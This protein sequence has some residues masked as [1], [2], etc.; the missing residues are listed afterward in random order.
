MNS[1]LRF[2][3]PVFGPACQALPDFLRAR[4]YRNPMA[5]DV[6][7]FQVAFNTEL[8]FPEFVKQ[9]PEHLENLHKSMQQSY[10]NQWIDEFPVESEL[11]Q[12]DQTG[13]ERP[14]LVDIGGGRGQQ[15]SAFKKRFP[16]LPGRVIVQDRAEVIDGVTEI[17]GVE[18]MVHDFFEAQP[19]LGAKF[20]YL[21]FV[22]HDWPDDL[23]VQILRS[24]VPAM[25]PQSCI[26]LDEMIPPDIGISFWAAFM[27][28]AM[29]ATCG[30][31]ERSA[32]DWVR[33][34]DRAGLRILKLLEYDPQ[35]LS[36]IVAVPKPEENVR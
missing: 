21:R 8:T 12:W 27:D 19:I 4:E 6:T 33:L 5:D 11:G 17:D 3:Q 2:Q 9:H 28:T 25:G 26:I 7:A 36:V 14:L 18:F 1:L 32:E 34:L 15:A 31:S 20:Y 23:C 29:L 22:L 16:G 13:N 24:I 35:N 30:G 10:G